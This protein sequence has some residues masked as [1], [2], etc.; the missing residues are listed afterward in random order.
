[1]TP[2]AAERSV[3]GLCAIVNETDLAE[4]YTTF[5]DQ[6]HATLHVIAGATD[7]VDRPAAG[8]LLEAKQRVEADLAGRELQESFGADVER[9]IAATR[10]ALES[11]GLDA[12]A[13][14]A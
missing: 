4:A 14:P 11:I 2:G 13:C 7:V 3:L 6:S 12:P 1:V 10:G 8:T 9:L 5:F